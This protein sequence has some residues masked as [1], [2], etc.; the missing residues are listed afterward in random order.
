MG[1][2][3]DRRKRLL[4]GIEGLVDEAVAAGSAISGTVADSIEGS[5]KQTMQGVLAGRDRVVMVRMNE[6][7]LKRLDELV[8]AGI[9]SSR[10]EAAALLIGEGIK[11]REGLFDKISDKTE[12]IRK[13]REEL[14]AM[15]DEE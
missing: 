5:L 9:V 14:R 6:G 13:A 1:E 4:E 3:K 12:E 2:N 10:S 15:L 11:S 7:S 8:E